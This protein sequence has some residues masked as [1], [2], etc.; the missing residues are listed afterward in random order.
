MQRSVFLCDYFQRQYIRL[1]L[2][3]FYATILRCQEKSVYT[4]LYRA[5]R[6]D[7]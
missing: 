3:M 7:V 6:Q 1:V 5:R 4:A 2:F